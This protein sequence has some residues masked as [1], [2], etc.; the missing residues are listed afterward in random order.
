MKNTGEVLKERLLSI[1]RAM[2]EHPERYA[3]TRAR[4]LPGGGR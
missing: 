4:I 2:G 1:I 3:K